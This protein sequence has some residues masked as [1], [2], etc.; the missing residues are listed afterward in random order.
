MSFYTIDRDI[1]N[2][3]GI[4][5]AECPTGIIEISEPGAFPVLI[6]GAEELCINCGH[7]VAVCPKG[8][9]SLETMTPEKIKAVRKELLPDP[10][11]VEHFLK[12]RRSVRS[13][14][15]KSV[16]REILAQL[17]DITRY[18]ASGHN[19]QPLHW[20]VFE[21][22]KELMRLSGM[23]VDWMR[24][25]VNSGVGEEF[26]GPLMCF[27]NAW[28]RGEDSIL[29]NTPN[30]IL[31]HAHSSGLLIQENTAIA[32]TYL[33]LAAYSLG[34]GSCWAGAFQ[35][36]AVLFPALTEVLKLPEGHQCTGVMMIGYPSYRFFRIPERDDSRITWR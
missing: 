16:P 3:D 12:T 33:E 32:M 18:A 11:Q 15:R 10:E 30:I 27:I 6:E 5:A 35:M 20:M 2:R 17:L 28:D 24:E 26:S 1:C 22:K 19:D 8:A 4:C 23:V 7:C 31:C 34:L 21:D 14:K 36:A 29:R 9:F 25:M 13:F